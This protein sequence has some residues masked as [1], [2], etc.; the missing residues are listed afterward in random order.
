[1]P[2]EQDKAVVRRFVEEVMMHRSAFPDIHF[3]TGET[4][5]AGDRVA[6]RWTFTGTHEGDMMGVEP[7]GR[8][9]E[10]SGVEINHVV[11]TCTN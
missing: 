4:F 2:A 8:R 5:A 11:L 1:M 6:H 7:T 3:H 10:V 9:V